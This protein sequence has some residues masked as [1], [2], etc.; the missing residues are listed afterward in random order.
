MYGREVR[1]EA[2]A[3][4]VKVNELRPSRA[5]PGLDQAEPSPAQGFGGPTAQAW[6][7]SG[8]TGP[9]GPGL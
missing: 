5:R 6:E 4:L 1:S 7:M 9:T 8:Q 3:Y 2:E